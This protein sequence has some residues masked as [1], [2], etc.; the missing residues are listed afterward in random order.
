[1]AP[2]FGENR[3][4]M[5][6][7]TEV[8][9]A[10]SEATNQHQRLIRDEVGLEMR[11]VWLTTRDSLVCPICGPKHGMP[12]EEWR[13]EFPGGPPGH[14]NCRCSSELTMDDEATIRAEALASQTARE[15]LLREKVEG[16][17]PGVGA[18]VQAGPPFATIEAARQALGSEI[19]VAPGVKESDAL[20]VLNSVATERDALIQRH[21]KLGEVEILG[22]DFDDARL[23]RDKATATYYEGDRII[24]LNSKSATPQ[25]R[26]MAAKREKL[27]KSSSTCTDVENL[28]RH[29]L[30]HAVQEQL[31]TEDDIFVMR[32]EF[33]DADEGLLA[34]QVSS[35]A[36][37]DPEEAFS[38]M[39]NLMASGRKRS[40]KVL[41]ETQ[42]IIRRILGD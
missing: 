12:E 30:G 36:V 32:D 31:L 13:A 27:K 2:A 17:K 1:L 6:A 9:R 39:F 33:L 41:P 25:A 8:T 20:D 4:S 23:R 24:T 40:F 5:I 34:R 28:Y 15:K 29:E 10:Y 14:V 35:Y 26:E 16:E 7:V 37:T 11:R 19:Y 21:P 22:L 38:E 42:E 18:M 3:A